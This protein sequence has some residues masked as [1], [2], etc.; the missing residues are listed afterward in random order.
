MLTYNQIDPSAFPEIVSF[1]T[2][3][4][5]DGNS[6]EG[7][8]EANFTVTEDGTDESPITVE[9]V[10]GTT[11][12]IT[13]TL[14]ID[15]SGSMDGQPIEDAKAAANTFVDLLNLLDRAAIISFNE[16]VTVDQSLTA[17][18]SLLHSAINSLVADGYTAIYDAVI[19]SVNE[20]LLKQVKRLLFFCLM[21]KITRAPTQL[22]KLSAWL[23]PKVFLFIRSD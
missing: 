11:D 2:V 21:G 19:V 16:Y 14:T 6:I 20:S 15:R 1:V 4:D 5:P 3:T 10:E 7:L 8:T 9:P 23:T 18:K 13:V 22:M 12:K 17:D